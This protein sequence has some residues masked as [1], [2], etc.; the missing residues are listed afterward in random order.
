MWGG[1]GLGPAD[2]AMAV[3]P[4]AVWG[5]GVSSR[6][7]RVVQLPG[8]VLLCLGG[9]QGLGGRRVASLLQATAMLAFAALRPELPESCHRDNS[10]DHRSQNLS[11]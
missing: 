2:L 6:L 8:G 3:E 5:R 10:T 9:G 7:L 11:K 1:G 4:G